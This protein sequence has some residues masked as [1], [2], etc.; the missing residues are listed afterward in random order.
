MKDDKRKKWPRLI[1]SRRAVLFLVFA[2]AGLL[3][4]GWATVDFSNEEEAIPLSDEVARFNAQRTAASDGVSEPPLTSEEVLTSIQS[5]LPTFASNP[6]LQAVF[7]RIQLTKQ[8]PM[9]SRIYL[10]NGF[11]TDIEPP[12]RLWWINLEVPLGNGRDYTLTIRERNY[13]VVGQTIP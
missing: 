6:S 7:K 13:P 9:K 2:C 12:I 4:A 1:F 11:P 10:L 3:W 5:H 8:L